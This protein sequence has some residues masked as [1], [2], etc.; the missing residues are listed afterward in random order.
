MSY[1][2]EIENNQTYA[3]SEADFHFSYNANSGGGQ[4]FLGGKFR[5]EKGVLTPP[6]ILDSYKALFE[7]IYIDAEGKEKSVLLKDSKGEYEIK[8][9]G[10][11]S[12]SMK[13]GIG[14]KMKTPSKLIATFFMLPPTCVVKSPNELRNSILTTNNYWLQSMWLKCKNTN[15]SEVHLIP[16]DFVFC[17]GKSK[18]NKGNERYFKLEDNKRVNDIIKI[19]EESNMLP[20][21]ISQRIRIFADVYLGN[22]PFDYETCS[23]SIVQIMQILA[24]TYPDKYSGI[25]DPLSFINQFLYEKKRVRDTSFIYT[26]YRSFITAIKTKPFLLLAGISGTGKSR[27]VRELARTCWDEDSIEYKAQKPKNFEMVQVKPNWHDSTELMGYISRVSGEPIFVAGDFLKFIV[28]AWENIDVPYFLCLDE[29]NLAP[30]EQYFTEFLSVIESRKRNDDGNVITDPIIKPEFEINKDSETK[31]IKSWYSKLIKELLAECPLEKVFALTKE[32][33]EYGISIPQNLIVIGTVN[34]DETTF[35]FSR[36]VLDRAMTIEMNE[37][38]LYAGLDSKYEHIGKLDSDML[39]GTAVEGVD[40]YADNEEVCNK[41]LSYLQAVNDVLNGTPFKIAYRTRNEFLLYVVNNLP[42]NL[43]EKGNEFSEDEVIAIA[44]DEIT[45]M[46]ILSR[47]EGDDTK[48]K[49]SLLE[50]LITTIEAQLLILTGEEKKIES[51][52][53]AKLKEMKERLTLSGYT[54][55]WS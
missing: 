49:H 18:D 28:K 35:S 13:L 55:F 26:T 52:S 29:M 12:T 20:N 54:S 32:F 45:S 44:L 53:V 6:S 27:I 25:E 46:K 34:M 10:E 48:I 5:N 50:S 4:S 39:I 24:E 38:D 23:D 22:K 30:V 37:V 9:R 11:G 8:P 16:L 14:T 41:V 40:V 17:G 36:K 42:Y 43:D 7:Y 1:F 33:E 19:A 3:N 15:E 47:I 2:I 21:D 51:I 31:Q